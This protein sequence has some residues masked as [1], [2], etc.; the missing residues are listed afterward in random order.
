MIHNKHIIIEMG[1]TKMERKAP[2]IIVT[3]QEKCTNSS[4]IFLIF[5]LKFVMFFFVCVYFFTFLTLRRYIRVRG[6]RLGFIAIKN[7]TMK[8]V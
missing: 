7:Y 4:S 2:L 3:I 8:C 6:E 5:F 1:K